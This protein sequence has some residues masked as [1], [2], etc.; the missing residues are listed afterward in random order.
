MTPYLQHSL[1]SLASELLAP[2]HGFALRKRLIRQL[3]PYAAVELRR[4]GVPA[5]GF[6]QYDLLLLNREH[7]PLGWPLDLRAYLDYNAPEFASCRITVE[8]VSLDD[9]SPTVTEHG[10]FW[11]L[12]GRDI[13]AP[14]ESVEA[15]QMYV[16]KLCA[17]LDIEG[18]CE[19]GAVLFAGATP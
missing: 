6:Q 12:Y 11:Y 1:A 10:T 5:A 17:L 2:G 14:W 19:D 9:L 15:A 18:A 3:L 8:S 4:R 16:R 7:K 13:P